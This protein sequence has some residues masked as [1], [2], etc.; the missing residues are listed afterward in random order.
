[1][2]PRPQRPGHATRVLRHAENEESRMLNVVNQDDLRW[3][4]QRDDALLT[5]LLMQCLFRGLQCEKTALQ[6]IREF[7]DN[8]PD[9]LTPERFRM[10]GPFFRFVATP[11]V[12]ALVQRIEAWLIEA[13]ARKEAWLDE[14]DEQGR[15][16]R[17]RHIGKI[18]HAV[19]RMEKDLR[20]W[21]PTLIGR[22]PDPGS[23]EPHV[24]VV[25]RL[26]DGFV[27]VWLKTV[28]ALRW[29]GRKMHHC[30][31]NLSHSQALELGN[32]KYYS[33]RDVR[34]QPHVTLRAC[35]RKEVEYRGYRNSKAWE[36][37]PTIAALRRAMGWNRTAFERMPDASPRRHRLYAHACFEREMTIP[38]NLDLSARG[39]F[40]RLPRRL[41]VEGTLDLSHNLRFTALPQTLEVGGDLR[42][43]GCANLSLMP[44]WLKVG[45]DLD[46]TGCSSV[47]RMPPACGVAG[48]INLTGCSGLRSV[49]HTLSVDGSL[50]LDGCSRLKHIPCDVA[51]GDTINIGR[52]AY[53]T[54][55]DVNRRL[56]GGGW[57]AQRRRR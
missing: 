3:F 21:H 9:W 23:D 5:V 43:G 33:L 46:M 47:T 28:E 15:V 6:E 24:E 49:P 29:E 41:K 27:W 54:I 4:L 2:R 50:R 44:R 57:L 20:R 55:A 48:S 25:L 18:S 14:R 8:A 16:Q 56:A 40:L 37:L 39:Y 31:G 26:D 53:C 11:D 52:I 38:G 36:F 7:P 10:G 45:G 17:L 32:A 22:R 12:V 35:D 51:V 1:M 30:V 42:L 13:I 34:G 19:D